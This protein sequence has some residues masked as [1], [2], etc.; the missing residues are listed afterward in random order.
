MIVHP[1]NALCGLEEGEE[2]VVDVR[3][4]CC[5][6]QVGEKKAAGEE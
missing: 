6:E 3:V 5:G 1:C 4:E 2:H